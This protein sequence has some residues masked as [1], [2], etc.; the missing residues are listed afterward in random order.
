[1]QWVPIPQP[2]GSKAWVCGHSLAGI[3]GSNPAVGINVMIVLRSQVDV[4][5]WGSSLVQMNPTDCDASNECDH[6]GGAETRNGVEQPR[7]KKK[8][9]GR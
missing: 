4:S 8:N 1:M 7:V 3:V 9:Y 6:E 2:V 5:E